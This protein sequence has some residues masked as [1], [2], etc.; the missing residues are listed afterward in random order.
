MASFSTDPRASLNNNPMRNSPS[1]RSTS[2]LHTAGNNGDGQQQHQQQQRSSMTRPRSEADLMVSMNALNLNR[3]PSQLPSLPLPPIPP[4]PHHGLAPSVSSSGLPS[5]AVL[6]NFP[7]APPLRFYRPNAFQ[8]LTLH[9]RTHGLNVRLG[10][11]CRTAYRNESE[12]CNGYVFSSRPICAG[13]SWVVQVRSITSS[14]F[15]SNSLS[16]KS[17]RVLEL[18]V[19][20]E[21]WLFSLFEAE[22]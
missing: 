3:G 8:P 12:F 17:R 10:P 19:E 21:I 14:Q 16:M 1:Q 18:N 9:P 4:Q 13:E 2:S 5:P 11:D 6:Q 7:T 20:R 22:D 15:V